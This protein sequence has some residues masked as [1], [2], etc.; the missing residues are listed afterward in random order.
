MA[1]GSDLLTAGAVLLSTVVVFA[2]DPGPAATPDQKPRGK[3]GDEAPMSPRRPNGG[4]MSPEFQNAR[5]ALEA[6]TPEQRQRFI[7]NFKRW[8]NLPPEEKKALADRELVRRKKI[9]EE[10][11]QA[12]AETNLDLTGE[13]RALFAKRYGEERR[14]VEEQ[15]RKELEEKRK[16]LIKEIIARLK[17]EFSAATLA[18][19]APNAAQP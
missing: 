7:E 2:E 19:P 5:R 15:L 9:A 3:R 6:L 4:P 12:L 17:E 10:V 18:S 14:K 13:R 1:R 16:P 8:S 11:N